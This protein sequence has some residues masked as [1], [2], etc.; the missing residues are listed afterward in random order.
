[1]AHR[2]I[3]DDPLDGEDVVLAEPRERAPGP[4]VTPVLGLGSV[5]SVLL[6]VLGAI[7]MLD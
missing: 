5:A 7:A 3:E 6:L 2:W 1:M 4:G